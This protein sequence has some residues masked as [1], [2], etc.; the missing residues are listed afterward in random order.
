MVPQQTGI[1]WCVP[2]NSLSSH[3]FGGK[4][5]WGPGIPNYIPDLGKLRLGYLFCP[6]VGERVCLLVCVP[7]RLPIRVFLLTLCMCSF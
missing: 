5:C 4:G 7:V 6:R 2:L 3:P 1:S